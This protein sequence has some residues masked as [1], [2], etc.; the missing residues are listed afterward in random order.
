MPTLLRTGL[1]I[2]TLL[3]SSFS[4]AKDE[5]V[6]VGAY[7]Y[8][9]F[10]NETNKTGLYYELSSA[11]EQASG[12]ALNWEFYPYARVNRLFDLGKVHMEIGSAPSWNAHKKVQGLYTQSFYQLEDV[13]IFRQGE[14]KRAAQ[15]EDIKGQD[16]G[17]VRG[18]SF[19]QFQ[20]VFNQGLAR[21]IDS[22]NEEQ[23]LQLLINHRIDQVFMSR[24]VFYYLRK[25]NPLYASLEIGDVVGQYDVAIRVHPSKQSIIPKLNSAIKLLKNKGAIEK[26][27]N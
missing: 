27:F 23:L 21:R 24:Q 10:M 12:I 2:L 20:Q 22:P 13:S 16:I 26:I 14:Q 1:L 11:I 9:P 25:Q 7:H 15:F 5:G 6:I 18:Y 8:P 3:A 4:T 19:P 17:I